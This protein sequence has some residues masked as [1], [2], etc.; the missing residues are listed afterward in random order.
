[1]PVSGRR[2]TFSALADPTRRAILEILR[3]ELSLTAGQIAAQF[4]AISRAAVSKHLGVLRD[5][6]LVRVRE[7]GRE[8]H[9]TLDPGPLAE[10]YEQW[11][12]SFAPLW[13]QTLSRLKVTAERPPLKAAPQSRPE[14][15]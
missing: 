9:Y 14:Q 10:V 11:L 7:E 13:D 6:H 1:M 3:D 15:R 2:D 12:V 5:A 8:W 4:P